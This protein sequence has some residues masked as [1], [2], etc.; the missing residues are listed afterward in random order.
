MKIF[1][2]DLQSQMYLLQNGGWTSNMHAARDFGSTPRAFEALRL[3][4]GRGLR[5]VY[6]FENQNYAIGARNW[7]EHGWARFCNA[8]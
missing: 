5:V 1:V 2:Q 4:H 6:Y 8:A 3:E 7:E